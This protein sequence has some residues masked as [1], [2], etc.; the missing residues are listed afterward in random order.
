MGLGNHLT[1][2][3]ERDINQGAFKFETNVCAYGG[4]RDVKHAISKDSQQPLLV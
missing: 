3:G 1:M 2:G 4:E